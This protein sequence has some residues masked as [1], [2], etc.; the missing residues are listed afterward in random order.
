MTSDISQVSKYK[1]VRTCYHKQ[2]LPWLIAQTTSKTKSVSVSEKILWFIKYYI[3][4]ILCYSSDIR[5]K[6]RSIFI[7]TDYLPTLFTL[8]QNFKQH[9]RWNLFRQWWNLFQSEK[10]LCY[11]HENSFDF[12]FLQIIY[13]HQI[14]SAREKRPLVWF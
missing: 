2:S 14:T 3:R 4:K 11:T 6:N 7:S 1:K 8:T 9:Q 10:I 12:F 13:L 5:K